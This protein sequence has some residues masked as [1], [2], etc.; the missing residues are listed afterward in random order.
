METVVDLLTLERMQSSKSW[1]ITW[2]GL[3]DFL[4]AKPSPQCGAAGITVPKES[5]H[6]VIEN[7]DQG[8]WHAACKLRDKWAFT[9]CE[10]EKASEK[11]LCTLMRRSFDSLI[12]D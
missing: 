12:I 8:F 5:K 1:Q 7:T 11:L 4:V 2:L 3:S 10:A 9:R 6:V